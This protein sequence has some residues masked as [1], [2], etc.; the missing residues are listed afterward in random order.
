LPL[1]HGDGTVTTV[2]HLRAFSNTCT[3]LG[4]NDNDSYMLLFMNSLQGNVASL[5][6]NLPDEC[7]STWSELSYWFTSTFGQLDNPYEHLKRFNQLHMNDNERILAFNLRFI[8]SYNSIPM[9]IFPTNLAA[10]LL[11]YELLPP[12]YQWRLEEKNVQNLELDLITCLDFEEQSQRTCFSFGVSDS[13]KYLSSL[14]P[15]IKDLQDHMLFLIIN[16]QI[17]PTLRCLEP[18]LLGPNYNDFTICGEELGCEED[19]DHIM[20]LN[21]Q[22]TFHIPNI[23]LLKPHRKTQPQDH[24]SFQASHPH[25]Y[26][27]EVDCAKED[28]DFNLFYLPL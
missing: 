20:M 7:I 13:Y 22:P 15:I 17:M 26:D 27:G 25:T 21:D 24:L 8:K 19:H 9:S 6:S 10:L 1:F 14:I 11:Y 3:I 5:F 23:T 2:E 16:L 12:L 28:I 4:V 18:S